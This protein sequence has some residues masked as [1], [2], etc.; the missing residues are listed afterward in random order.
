MA[1]YEPTPIA[2]ITFKSNSDIGG[3]VPSEFDAALYKPR[4]NAPFKLTIKNQI[5]ESDTAIPTVYA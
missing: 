5:E 4:D 1:M 2:S 3:S